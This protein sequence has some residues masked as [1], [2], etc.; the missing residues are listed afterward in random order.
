M[1]ARAGSQSRLLMRSLSSDSRPWNIFGYA[2]RTDKEPELWWDE[3]NA[4]DEIMANFIHLV[5]ME[6]LP[7]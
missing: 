4:D 1:A 5:L 2:G 7:I 3:M 6:L